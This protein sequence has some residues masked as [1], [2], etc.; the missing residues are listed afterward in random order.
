[1]FLYLQDEFVQIIDCAPQHKEVLPSLCLYLGDYNNKFQ[2]SDSST[3]NKNNISQ[4][5]WD[6]NLQETPFSPDNNSN[7]FS[8]NKSFYK[9]PFFHPHFHNFC[10]KFIRSSPNMNVFSNQKSQPN[11]S[12][13]KHLPRIPEYLFS[14]VFLL[15]SPPC[16][17]CLYKYSKSFTPSSEFISFLELSTS[18][19]SKK[20]L[21]DS[22]LFMKSLATT[23]MKKS[24]FISGSVNSNYSFSTVTN[25]LFFDF[26]NKKPLKLPKST[27]NS[28][29]FTLP[30]SK[31]TH[32]SS[33]QSNQNAVS[34]PPSS[35]VSQIGE[36]LNKNDI[37]NLSTPTNIL[38]NSL[39]STPNTS[40]SDSQN[41]IFE[42][43]KLK[44][45]VFKKITPS[46]SSYSSPLIRHAKKMAHLK[47]IDSSNNVGIFYQ[48]NIFI[49]GQGISYSFDSF[50]V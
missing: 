32:K 11:D 38:S 50:L 4:N 17:Y 27:K 18:P 35:S 22:G 48:D 49:P 15:L 16:Y 10:P 46:V 13:I 42:T 45:F 31:K 43:Q 25:S 5:F 8:K 44:P 3:E 12:K 21:T 26:Q 30:F 2:S 6:I 34:L 9:N 40:V 14:R 7:N 23:I 39:F 19:Y 47:M 24:S 28:H 41:S 20:S 33:V 29:W 37:G 1:L 36:N